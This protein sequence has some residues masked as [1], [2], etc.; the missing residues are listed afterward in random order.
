MTIRKIIVSFLLLAAVICFAQESFDSPGF[1]NQPILINPNVSPSILIKK[2]LGSTPYKLTPGDTYELVIKL[3]KTERISLI[4]PSDYKLELPYLGTYDARNRYFAEFRSSIIKNIKKRLPVAEYVDFVLTSLSLFDVTIYGGVKTPG[5]VTA[6]PLNS[7][8]EAV[9]AAG[10]LKKGAGTRSIKLIREGETITC[11]RFLY[12]QKA[13]LSQNPLLQPG[14]VIFIPHPDILVNIGGSVTYPDMYEII[15]GETLKELILM[16]GGLLPDAVETAIEVRRIEKTG[17][18]TLLR[19]SLSESSGVELQNGDIINIPSVQVMQDMI[20]VEAALFGKPIQGDT[21]RIIPETPILLDVPY[22]SGLT[23]LQILDKFGGPTPLAEADKS[24]IIRGREQTQI[25]VDAAELWKSRRSD[26]DLPLEP[27]DHIFIPMKRLSVVVAGQVNSPGTFPYITGSRVSDYIALA[28]GIVAETTNINRI[29]SIDESG[30][31]TRVRLRDRV[32]P[33]TTIYADKN[34]WKHTTYTLG[35]TGIV[36]G[37]ASS[38]IA[39]IASII[40]LIK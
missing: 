38:V 31:H 1:G 9:A 40:A 2:I 26:L 22:V 35:E 23:L 30:E 27:G 6:T 7:V 15:P 4:L 11:D 8:W 18:S 17:M 12:T 19:F 21:P 33:G 34:A 24:M 20:L 32:E 39:L 10:G 3:E 25:P 5:R 28:G 37:F 16:A 13:D 36:I 29:Y 14:D